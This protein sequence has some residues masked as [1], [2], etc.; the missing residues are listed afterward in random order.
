MRRFIEKSRESR[1]NESFHTGCLWRVCTNQVWTRVGSI[2]IHFRP[3]SG[4][5][6][7]ART[8]PFQPHISL[9]PVNSRGTLVVT[10]RLAQA[11]HGVHQFLQM[12][13]QVTRPTLPLELEVAFCK[14]S[15]GLKSRV[16]GAV[17]DTPGCCESF[18]RHL[19]LQFNE[20][21]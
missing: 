18:E 17:V 9:K 11:A 5:F 4:S 7:L 15:L 1:F 14:T 3:K 16:S 2:S 20:P 21:C 12:R 19:V 6:V 8:I 13:E 10:K